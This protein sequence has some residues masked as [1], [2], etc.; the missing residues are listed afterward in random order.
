ML[1][2]IVGGGSLTRGYNAAIEKEER[3]RRFERLFGQAVAGV[4]LI[5]SGVVLGI[6]TGF[7]AMQMVAPDSPSVVAILNLLPF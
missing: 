6:L 5:L 2:G 1:L 7:G 3:D 4:C